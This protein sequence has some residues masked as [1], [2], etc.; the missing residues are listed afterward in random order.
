MIGADLNGHVEE[1][2]R[3]LAAGVTHRAGDQV[4]FNPPPVTGDGQVW[5]QGNEPGGQMMV[6]LAKRSKKK[7]S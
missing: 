6:N 4:S 5:W 3:T 2:N 7:K 1:G